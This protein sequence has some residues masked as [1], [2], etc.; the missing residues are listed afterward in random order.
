MLIRKDEQIITSL[1]DQDLYK[2]TMMQ[3]VMFRF[4]AA[5]VRHEFHLRNTDVNLVKHQAE[6]KEQI[7]ALENLRFQPSELKYLQELRFIRQEFIPFLELFRFKTS[8][9][10]VE[11]IDNEL[12]ISTFGPWWQ[13]ILY[14]IFV[15]SIVNEVYFQNQLKGLTNYELSNIAEQ[16]RKNLKDKLD[17]IKDVD[18]FQFMEFGTRRR[19]SK[20]WQHEAVDYM[21]RYLPEGRLIGTSNILLAKEFN[22]KPMGTMAHEYL[23]AFQ[24][25]DI[26]QLSQSQETALETWANFYEGDLGIALTDVIDMDSFL[27]AFNRRY[28]KEFDGL[29]HDSG[30]PISW[31]EKAI[32]HYEALNIDPKSKVLVFSDGLNFQ[33]ALDIHKHFD[34]RIKNSYGIGTN[35][36]N[37]LGLKPLNIVM[38]MV[39][40]NGKP[41]AKISDEPGKSLCKD[42]AY[43]DYLIRVHKEKPSL[44]EKPKYLANVY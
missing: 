15:L 20:E 23:Q 33:K 11:V 16:G 13:T 42:Q 31:G 22:L 8:Q 29:R 27:K 32:K 43:L 14:E 39:E 44:F 12:K 35:I 18:G 41:V 37:D 4:P 38:K 17:I 21:T 28:A 24:A 40:C 1:L 36:T 26:C 9:I 25:L 6:I 7:K 30:D 2:L 34:G 3:V 5:I 19:F 10:K